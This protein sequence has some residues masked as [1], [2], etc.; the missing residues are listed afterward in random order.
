MRHEQIH[1]LHDVQEHLHGWTDGR[2]IRQAIREG[3]RGGRTSRGK[4]EGGEGAAASEI[5]GSR[6]IRNIVRI[7]L[8]S[9]MTM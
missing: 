8:D 5:A 9:I 3:L 7:A 1:A 6:H 2:S 4:R